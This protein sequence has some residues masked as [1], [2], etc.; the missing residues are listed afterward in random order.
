MSNDPDPNLSDL[1]PLP[2]GMKIRT[3]KFGANPVSPLFPVPV[4]GDRSDSTKPRSEFQIRWENQPLGVT[5]LVREREN[6][7]L[8]ADVFCTNADLLDKA[9]V[10]VGLMGTTDQLIRKSIPLNVPAKNGCGGSAD[11][12]PLT[13]AVKEL[14]PQLGVVVFLLLRRPE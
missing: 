1:F 7:H 8:I 10:S 5:A 3:R 6:G 11:F 4:D 13:A 12:G 9:W 14:G 2:K